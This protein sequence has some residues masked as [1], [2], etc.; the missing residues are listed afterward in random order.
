MYAGAFAPMEYVRWAK[1]NPGTR[2]VPFDANRAASLVDR[3]AGP[4]DAVA[5]DAGYGTWIHPAFGK[6]L[7]RPV[8]LIAQGTGP[9]H[10]PDGARWVAIDRSF[11][12]IWEHPDFE[13]L[14]QARKFL[15]RGQP[16]PE[17]M[18]VF[19]ALRQD[20]RFELV[21]YNRVTN[22]AVFRRTQ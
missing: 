13:D 18:R 14:S 15:V 11:A 6:E 1:L 3:R 21:V 4:R 10:I 12:S 17:E 22:Q 7:Q 16:K 19:N 8:Y 5:V 2:V 20:P 9:V